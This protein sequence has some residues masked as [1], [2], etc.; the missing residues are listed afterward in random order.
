MPTVIAR[1]RGIGRGVDRSHRSRALVNHVGG[2]AVRGDRNRGRVAANADRRARLIVRGVDRSHRPR[3]LVR[4]V[5]V[6]HVGGL[7]V[8]ADRDGARARAHGGRPPAILVA[9]LIG[10]TDPKRK[11]TTYAV[12]PS[13]VIATPN[14]LPP[15]PIAWRTRLVAVSIGNTHIAPCWVTYAVCAVAAPAG[16]T[17]SAVATKPPR[18]R[19]ATHSHQR[20][21][22][23]ASP[24][25]PLNA[26]IITPN[27]QSHRPS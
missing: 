11:W 23:T 7:A 9:V 17:T 16:H 26:L 12:L 21:R 24:P 25:P 1:P 27:S 3:A 6:R 10:V 14:D 19:N 15:T 13:G 8:R 2:L 18:Q 4:H 22:P 5:L 20:P